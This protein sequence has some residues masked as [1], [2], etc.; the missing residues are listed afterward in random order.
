MAESVRARFVGPHIDVV[1]GERTMR[2]N[3][4]SADYSCPSPSEMLSVALAACIAQTVAVVAER[5]GNV[6][7]RLEVTVRREDAQVE[8]KPG[9]LFAVHLDLGDGLAERDRK[10][11]FHAAQHCQVFK[12]LNGTKSFSYVLAE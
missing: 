2:L 9:S 3:G 6:L 1:V 10:V 4:G 11:L 8:G 7:N 5:R 12:L